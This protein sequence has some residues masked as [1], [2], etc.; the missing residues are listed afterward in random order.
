VPMKNVT[1]RF[2]GRVWELIQEEAAIDG[3]SASQFVREAALARAI[4]AQARRD[5][6]RL[7][8]DILTDVRGLMDEER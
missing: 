3:I 8:E 1:L 6:K 4:H 5:P 7:W 2:G